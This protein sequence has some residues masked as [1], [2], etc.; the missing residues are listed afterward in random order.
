MFLFAPP[1]RIKTEVYFRLPDQVRK[2]QRK[3]TR[4]IDRPEYIVGYTPGSATDITARLFA[5]K[6]SEAWKVTVTVENVPAWLPKLMMSNVSPIMGVKALI[7]SSG[8]P[9]CKQSVRRSCSNLKG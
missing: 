8:Y 7:R 3:L 4:D 2:K 6:F 5:Q 9:R 1:I